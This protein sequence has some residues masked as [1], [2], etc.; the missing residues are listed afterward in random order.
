MSII[1]AY[2][3]ELEFEAQSTR[4]LLALVPEDKFDWKPHEKSMTL[5]SLAS[6]IANSFSWVEPVLNQDELSFD[7]ESHQPWMAKSSADLLSTFDANVA[8]ALELM[9]NVPDENMMKPWSMKIKD[10]VAFSMPKAA[11]LRMF[12]FSHMIHH[13][14]QLDVYL[15]LNDIP[16]PQVYGPS[17]DEQEMAK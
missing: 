4:K 6:H 3:K 15:R 10:Q 9:K 5:N 14:G 12:I 11:V 1:E 16:L 7:P 13:R 17:A 2:Q 8:K